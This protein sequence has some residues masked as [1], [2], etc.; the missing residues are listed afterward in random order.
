M[1]STK[2]LVAFA[3]DVPITWIFEH[4]LKLPTQL[5]G[6]EIAIKSPFNSRDNNP[7]LT[8]YIHKVT[9]KYL[10]KDFSTGI[11]GNGLELVKQLW[12]KEKGVEL[13]KFELMIKLVEDYNQFILSGDYSIAQFKEHSKYKVVSSE[14][15]KWNTLDKKYW[16]EYEISSKELELDGVWPLKRYDMKKEEDG[17]TLELNIQGEFIYGFYRADG[18]LY[19]IYQPKV[20][21]R[22]FMKVK[23]YV[24]GMDQLKFSSPNLVLTSSVKD[25]RCLLNLGFNLESI[26]PD[27][28]NAMV[29]PDVMTAL[30]YKYKT[31][32]VMFD[33]DEAGH[34]SMAKYKERDGLEGIILT[35]AKDIA[36]AVKHIQM[37]VLK[38]LMN[39]VMTIYF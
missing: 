17:K 5:S 23:D 26:A 11:G 19:K 22:K 39:G 30:K 10:F 12:L 14:K 36:D 6:Q 29:K 4:Y 25:R 24:Q 1:I 3:E 34:K 20:T 32:L 8:V 13:T 27:S 21:D 15:R 28:E 18:S 38:V 7:S 37:I 31:I 9:G 2:S 35:V 33:N 16:N